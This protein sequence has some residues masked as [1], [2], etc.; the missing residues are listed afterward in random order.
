MAPRAGGCGRRR[1]VNYRSGLL[2]STKARIALPSPFFPRLPR[3]HPRAF[4]RIR[5]AP[6]IDDPLEYLCR[7]VHGGAGAACKQGDVEVSGATV[8]HGILQGS[9]T[10]AGAW[11]F[12]PCKNSFSQT[13]L[14][15]LCHRFAQQAMSLRQKH[16]GR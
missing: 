13:K 4:G 5:L 14:W 7:P 3:L 16:E 11:H 10:R 9:P 2:A 12:A 1:F 15:D 6:A 8:Q